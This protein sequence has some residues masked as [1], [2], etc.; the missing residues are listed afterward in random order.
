METPIAILLGVF[1]ILLGLGFFLGI[2]EGLE[3]VYFL[4]YTSGVAFWMLGGA[5]SA[6][7]VLGLLGG[8]WLLP[9]ILFAVLGALMGSFLFTLGSEERWLYRYRKRKAPISSL[10]VQE[11]LDWKELER[12]LRKQDR[13]KKHF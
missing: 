13:S 4:Y 7:A 6:V 2:T 9:V 1:V 10:E 5:A 11:G 12:W 3:R 8:I